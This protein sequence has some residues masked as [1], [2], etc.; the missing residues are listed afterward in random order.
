[1]QQ[2]QPKQ[3]NKIYISVNAVTMGFLIAGVVLAG[4]VLFGI[5]FHA[6]QYASNY[7]NTVNVI[8]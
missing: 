3:K 2:I 7:S 5:F 1:M 8:K 6:S 4:A